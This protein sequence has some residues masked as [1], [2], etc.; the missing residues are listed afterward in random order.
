MDVT[1]TDVDD[2]LARFERS[3]YR[4][5]VVE[6]APGGTVVGRVSAVDHD[7]LPFN[8]FHYQLVTP[9]GASD[10]NDEGDEIRSYFIDCSLGHCSMHFQPHHLY[11]RQHSL[12][13]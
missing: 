4:F 7:L 10:Q 3:W 11:I 6:N 1:V 9:P 2:E 8:S 12:S 13:F 5:D